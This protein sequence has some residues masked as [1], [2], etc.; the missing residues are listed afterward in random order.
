MIEFRGTLLEASDA[1][2]VFQNNL[3]QSFAS[4]PKYS[5]SGKFGEHFQKRPP[6]LVVDYKLQ[7]LVVLAAF[8]ITLQDFFWMFITLLENYQKENF[9][10]E[11][12][13]KPISEI[14]YL[15][16]RKQHFPE[17]VKWEIHATNSM[18]LIM[19][20][21]IILFCCYSC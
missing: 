21:C 5:F 7:I 3:Q 6:F 2:T 17:S 8:L 13:Q 15:K 9:F 10:Q 1:A 11:N 12:Y 20:K 4:W 16:K 19:S 14:Y 18:V